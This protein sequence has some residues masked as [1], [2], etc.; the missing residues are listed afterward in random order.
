MA[1]DIIKDT[2]SR[3]DANLEHLKEEYRG[4]RAGRASP[5]ILEPLTVEVY[6]SQMKLKELATITV[7][8]PKQ[9][10]ITPFDGAN[11]GP[12]SKAIEKSDLGL[13]SAVEGK[14]VRVFFPDLTQERRKDLINQ[15]HKKK[16]DCKISIRNV[17]R[18]QNE[19]LKKQKSDGIIPEDDYKHLEKEIQK[20]TDNACKEVDV[21]CTSKEK[22]ISTV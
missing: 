20:L 19:E 11:A 4:I 8:E 10:L 2:K 18:D 13:R 14:T 5:G 9:I 22:E 3:M 1:Q 21:L 12:I 17:R 15:C 6:G 7:P 16:E